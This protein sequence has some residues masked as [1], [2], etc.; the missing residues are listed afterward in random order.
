MILFASV[1]FGVGQSNLDV[2]ADKIMEALF[3]DHKIVGLSGA[4]SLEGEIKWTS[5]EGHAHKEEKLPFTSKT[6][7][8]VASITKSMTAVA[9]MQLVDSHDLDIDKT[10]DLFLPEYE[11]H[12]Y[13]KIT[14]RHLL[15]HMSGIGAYQS[16]KE[17]ETTN[18]YADLKSAAKVFDS[19]ELLFK[20][21]EKYAY[22][23]YGYVI[24][25]RVIEAVSGIK[26][27][28]YMQEYIF[29]KAGMKN[30]GFEKFENN[31]VGK[32]ELYNKGKRKSKKAKPNNLSNR[33]PGGG[34][35]S[36]VEDIMHFSHALIEG[37]LISEERLQDMARVQYRR[38]DGNP[39][40]LGFFIY[41]DTE[42]EGVLLGHS[43]TQTGSSCQLFIVPKNKTVV[44]ILAN[45]SNVWDHVVQAA[46]NL[47][48]IS[49]EHI[50]ELE[51]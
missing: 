23:T 39:Y 2:R 48:G 33:L 20:P 1:Q 8:R 41:Q 36:T 25:G 9:I 5:S 6:L 44:V 38:T 17:A 4:Y 22:T 34:C 28:A 21:G 50:E 46:G 27:E 43:G 31:Y 13:A 40:G 26:Y 51:K 45:T 10:I 37:K 12:P 11:G 24:L 47:L 15:A 32:S 29:E 42:G 30:S 35:Y 18:E 19:R 16:G 7:V 3:N 14:V 49:Q